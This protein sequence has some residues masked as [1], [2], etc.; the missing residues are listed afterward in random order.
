MASAPLRSGYPFRSTTVATTSAPRTARTSGM[1][2]AQDRATVAAGVVL[3]LAAAYLRY[4]NLS[5]KNPP[6]FGQSTGGR[7]Y[8]YTNVAVH[9]PRPGG[10]DLNH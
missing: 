9:A 2:V 10:M 8:G 1:S 6:D 5:W 3:R 4:E 7:L